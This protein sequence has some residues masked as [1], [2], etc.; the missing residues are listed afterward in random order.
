MALPG[1]SPAK[2]SSTLD[3]LPQGAGGKKKQLRC[4]HIFTFCACAL[5]PVR[6]WR[7]G[8]TEPD[9]AWRDLHL[10][11][12]TVLYGRISQP[13]V[14]AFPLVNVIAG[15]PQHVCPQHTNIS[16]GARGHIFCKT[17]SPFMPSGVPFRAQEMKRSKMWQNICQR[18]TKNEANHR[19]T[20]NSSNRHVD[21]L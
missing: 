14:F 15:K 5:W 6:T 11:R 13:Q 8:L 7:A 12:I 21:T 20:V 2:Q 3:L 1:D 17:F 4:V 19:R 18:Y 16:F 10:V 9:L